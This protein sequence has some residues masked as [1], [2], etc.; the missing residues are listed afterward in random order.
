MITDQK[1]KKGFKGIYLIDGSI[2]GTQMATTKKPNFFRRFFTLLFLGWK[3]ISLK[4]LKKK[5]EK[6]KKKEQRK[7]EKLKRKEQK[8]IEKSKKSSRKKKNK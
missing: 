7:S 6:I 3:W 8:K 5:Q 1:V 4:K 2:D